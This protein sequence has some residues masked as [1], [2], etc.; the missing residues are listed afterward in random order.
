MSNKMRYLTGGALILS[1]IILAGCGNQSKKEATQDTY[2]QTSIMRPATVVQNITHYHT[3]EQ[4]QKNN[5]N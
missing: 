3:E 4:Q 5:N 1:T 2:Y